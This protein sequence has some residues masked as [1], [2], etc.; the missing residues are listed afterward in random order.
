MSDNKKDQ[1]PI[2]D[3]PPF[4]GSWKNIYWLLMGNLAVLIL[5]FYL[6]TRHFS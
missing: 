3:Q 4:L 1:K 5:L 2:T 6:F